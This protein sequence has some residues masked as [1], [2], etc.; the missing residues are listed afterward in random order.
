M[1]QTDDEVN[2]YVRRMN[3]YL[4]CLQNESSDASSE[5][6]R[7]INDWNYEVDTFNSRR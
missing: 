4:Q 1:T 2:R 5:A 6:K 3:E 7:V